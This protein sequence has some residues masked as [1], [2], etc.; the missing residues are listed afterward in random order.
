MNSNLRAAQLF[1]LAAI[2][3]LAGSGTNASAAVNDPAG[4]SRDG[5][6]LSVPQDELDDPP[7][8]LLPRLQLTGASS[9]SRAESWEENPR[10]APARTETPVLVKN[11]F[12]SAAP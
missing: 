9:R 10:S 7:C 12:L 6:S 4:V 1:A 5:V 2:I 11:P 8:N 3:L